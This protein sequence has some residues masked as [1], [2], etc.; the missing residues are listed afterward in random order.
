MKKI[1]IISLCFTLAGCAS[2]FAR[3]KLTQLENEL[4]LERLQIKQLKESLGVNEQLLKEKD[5]KI[6]QLRKQLE[7]LGVFP[8]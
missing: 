5:A 3:G 2:L 1:L 7:S 4:S 8:K 6:E